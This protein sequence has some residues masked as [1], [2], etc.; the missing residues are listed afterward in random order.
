MVM[1]RA[2]M[3]PRKRFPMTKDQFI[4]ECKRAFLYNKTNDRSFLRLNKTEG[5]KFLKEQ[6]IVPY[7][8][9]TIGCHDRTV[10]SFFLHH[11]FYDHSPFY[12]APILFFN[13]EDGIYAYDDYDLKRKPIEL[14][15]NTIRALKKKE[16]DSLVFT[17]RNCELDNWKIV[18]LKKP[19][20]TI[21]QTR[22][23]IIQLQSILERDKSK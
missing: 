19:I 18:D 4:E 22:E 14:M 6:K 8:Y 1:M 10:V 7:E 11:H 13:F 2:I 3:T 12:P 20:I 5:K 16:N 9:V 23:T 21:H 17:M 15:G